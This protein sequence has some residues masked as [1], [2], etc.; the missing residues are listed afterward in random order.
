MRLSPFAIKQLKVSIQLRFPIFISKIIRILLHRGEIDLACYLTAFYEI[1]IEEDLV[2]MAIRRGW[3]KWLKYVFAFK[4][5]YVNGKHYNLK[6]LFKDINIIQDDM[7]VKDKEEMSG[8]ELCCQWYLRTDENI[9]E[10]LLEENQD[11]LTLK[12]LN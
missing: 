9:L 2:K 10:A 12:Y 11:L 6:K 4:K 1:Y 5:N 3:Y 7:D 8:I